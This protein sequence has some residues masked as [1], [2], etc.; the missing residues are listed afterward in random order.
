MISVSLSD[1]GMLPGLDSIPAAAVLDRLSLLKQCNARGRSCQVGSG[2]VFAHAPAQAQRC[3][4]RGEPD[5]LW[6]SV[7]G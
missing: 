3:T 5:Y 2:S 1:R 4:D 7:K 6:L